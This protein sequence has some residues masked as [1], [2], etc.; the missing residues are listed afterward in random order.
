MGEL[1]IDSALIGVRVK[2]F[3]KRQL[4]REDISTRCVMR[5]EKYRRGYRLRNRGKG[6][7]NTDDI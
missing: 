5:N 4:Y 3:N 7:N 1:A 6:E 2:R